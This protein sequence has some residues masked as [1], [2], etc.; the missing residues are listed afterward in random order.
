MHPLLF[1][2]KTPAKIAASS[3]GIENTCPSGQVSSFCRSSDSYVQMISIHAL[4]S[5]SQP[6]LSRSVTCFRRKSCAPY[7]QH[8]LRAYKLPGR[9]QGSNLIPLFSEQECVSH[10][11]LSGVAHTPQK[12]ELYKIGW[13]RRCF[14]F[15]VYPAQEKSQEKSLFSFSV[16]PRSL[17]TSCRKAYNHNS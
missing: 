12:P 5:P 1:M 14:Q 7:L 9:V 4:T 16:L 6:G 8:E 11:A 17:D 15:L 10:S 3:K 2:T 13:K